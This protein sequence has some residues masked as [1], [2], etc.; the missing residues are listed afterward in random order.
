MVPT[1]EGAEMGPV[2]PDTTEW[3]LPT[4]TGRVSTEKPGLSTHRAGLADGPYRKDGLFDFEDM[5][6]HLAVFV[7]PAVDLACAVDNRGV[8]PTT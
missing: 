2:G 4:R 6:P 3:E 1:P 8:V 5:L 7:D